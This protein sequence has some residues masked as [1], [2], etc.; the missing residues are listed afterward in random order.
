MSI[1]GNKSARK[2]KSDRTDTERITEIISKNFFLIKQNS[3]ELEVLSSIGRLLLHGDI[4][5]KG[6]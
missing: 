1:S 6:R 3:I 2:M 5:L 4:K